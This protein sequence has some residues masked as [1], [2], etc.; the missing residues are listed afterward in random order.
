MLA[1]IPNTLFQVC[2]S[3]VK[4][5]SIRRPMNFATLVTAECWIVWQYVSWCEDTNSAW[6]WFVKQSFVCDKDKSTKC[7]CSLAWVRDLH[8][9]SRANRRP[10]SICYVWQLTIELCF[11]IS[12]KCFAIRCA[13]WGQ[14]TFVFCDQGVGLGQMKR[15]ICMCIWCGACWLEIES[16]DR[17]WKLRVDLFIV[18]LREMCEF[19]WLCFPLWLTLEIAVR[20]LFM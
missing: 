20:N 10:F 15:L 7:S 9:D 8:I 5:V 2:V 4:A 1:C 16:Q 11:D 17:S 19:C 13:G 12:S 6:Q 3:K 18:K 14:K